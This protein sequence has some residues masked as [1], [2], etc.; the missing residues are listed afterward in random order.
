MKLHDLDDDAIGVLLSAVSDGNDGE[1]GRRPLAARTEAAYALAR[2]SKQMRD[3]VYKW[4]LPLARQM[5]THLGT[6]F[7]LHAAG[8]PEERPLFYACREAHVLR[9]RSKLSLS[10]LQAGGLWPN[11]FMQPDRPP[12]ATDRMCTWRMNLHLPALTLV[13]HR[14][15]RIE[16]D[17]NVC[18]RIAIV[19]K[20]GFNVHMP[21]LTETFLDSRPLPGLMK[22]QG[23]F[24]GSED[25][26]ND[27]YQ[28]HVG[29]KFERLFRTWHPDIERSRL[30]QKK[31]L[32]VDEIAAMDIVDDDGN[33]TIETYILE[34]P[35][36]VD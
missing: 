31:Y 22:R 25:G 21:G 34:Y 10:F 35:N 19:D 7:V 3:A 17:G 36:G 5:R 28:N 24:R 11:L 2:C 1:E 9:S 6:K 13:I 16:Q 4:A 18:I 8:S 26:W 32:S 29:V 27:Y 15:K 14:N 33:I 23:W 20:H 30:N 12:W